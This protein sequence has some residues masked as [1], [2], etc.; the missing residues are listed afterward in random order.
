MPAITLP[1]TTPMSS[2]SGAVWR[3]VSIALPT[4]RSPTIGTNIRQVVSPIVVSMKRAPDGD[5]GIAC[6]SVGL[7][8]MYLYTIAARGDNHK[9]P[10]RNRPQKQPPKYSAPHTTQSKTRY[11][12]RQAAEQAAKEQM[13]YHLDLV[14]HAYQSPTD[15]GW[16]LTSK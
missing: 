1:I 11:A 4:S 8:L 3:W 16:Y 7:V 15:G 2:Q 13:K 10:R 5:S 6:S 12:S 9:M 14:L